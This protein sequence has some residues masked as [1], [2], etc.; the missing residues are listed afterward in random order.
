MLIPTRNPF[1]T[2]FDAK[3]LIGRKFSDASVQSD[4]KLW[5]FK[6]IAGPGDKPMIVV[7]Y[8]NEEKQLTAEE[9]SSMVLI[10]MRSKDRRGEGAMAHMVTATSSMTGSLGPSLSERR[11][12]KSPWSL[13]Y[14]SQISNPIEHLPRK[15]DSIATL[16]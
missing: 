11:M 5:P 8:K 2:V 7:S 6:V 3:R 10:K 1:N 12:I 9:I 15:I 13:N 4:M 16:L 14:N